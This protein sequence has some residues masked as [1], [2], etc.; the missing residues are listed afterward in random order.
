MKYGAFDDKAS[1]VENISRPRQQNALIELKILCHI[2]N[3]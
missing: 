2:I 3:N 1:S